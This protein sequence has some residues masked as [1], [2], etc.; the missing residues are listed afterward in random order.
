MT[1]GPIVSAVET[2]TW[3]SASEARDAVANTILGMKGARAGKAGWLQYRLGST[4][5]FRTWGLWTRNAY[6]Q[7]PLVVDASVTDLGTERRVRL[8]FRSDEGPYLA[9]LDRVAPA[10]HRRFA[11]VAAVV[12]EQLH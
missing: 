5:W 3:K 7:L 9:R 12:Q 8:D 10:Y 1:L 2:V 4:A 11:E 6:K